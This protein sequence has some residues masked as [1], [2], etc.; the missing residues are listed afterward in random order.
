MV[1]YV[2]AT[3][4][5]PG[6]LRTAPGLCLCTTPG[7]CVCT[8]P[9]KLASEPTLAMDEW[10]CGCDDASR[11]DVRITKPLAVGPVACQPLPPIARPHRRPYNEEASLYPYRPRPR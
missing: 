8:A 1:A 11:A 10:P 3:P 2:E 7:L 6:R 4:M 5:Y 9:L